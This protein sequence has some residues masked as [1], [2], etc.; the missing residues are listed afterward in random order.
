MK[1]RYLIIAIAIPGLAGP[2]SAQ[3]SFEYLK[4]AEEGDTVV[5]APGALRASFGEAAV[6]DQGRVSFQ[7]DTYD[8]G[9]SG[10]SRTQPSSGTTAR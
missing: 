3:L 6:D 7:G 9:N 4:I 10:P 2:A 8:A 1:T 5:G